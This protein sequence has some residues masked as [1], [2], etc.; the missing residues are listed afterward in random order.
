M[1]IVFGAA[2]A[3]L[4]LKVGLTVSA[5]IPAAATADLAAAAIDL[6]TPAYALATGDLNGDGRADLVVGDPEVGQVRVY[7]R[8]PR[9]LG[10]LGPRDRPHVGRLTALVAS[11]HRGARDPSDSRDRGRGS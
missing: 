2:N 4:G 10:G 11:C 3:Y 5:S 1:G 8:A 9:R 7:Y 6:A